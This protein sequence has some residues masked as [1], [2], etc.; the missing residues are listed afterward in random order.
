MPAWLGET[1]DVLGAYIPNDRWLLIGCA[2]LV[3]VRIVLFLQKT[4]YGLVIRAGVE[5]RTMVT[6]L[7]IDVRRAF[8]IV[9][10]IGGAAAGLGGVLASVYYGHASAPTRAPR[11]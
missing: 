10:A 1:T 3:L 9:F 5:N 11:C 8:T 7:G 6:A 2:V 4:S